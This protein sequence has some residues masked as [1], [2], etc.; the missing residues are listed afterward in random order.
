MICDVKI[1]LA[2]I[3][4]CKGKE[5]CCTHNKKLPTKIPPNHGEKPLS[6]SFYK[7]NFQQKIWTVEN[8]LLLISI[9]PVKTGWES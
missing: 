9:S 5:L 7:A 6:N 3:K 8:G 1:L 4:D 2:E